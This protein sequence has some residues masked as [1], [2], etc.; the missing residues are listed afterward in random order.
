MLE[1]LNT[2][3]W[4]NVFEGIGVDREEVVDR[5][6]MVWDRPNGD[7]FCA[8]GVFAIK[9]RNYLLVIALYAED[10]C[11]WNSLQVDWFFSTE[12][13][14]NRADALI[15]F[16]PHLTDNQKELLLVPFYLRKH[17]AYLG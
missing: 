7:K 9:N 2:K 17:S 6:S 15:E 5:V 14:Q 3:L 16:L 13:A 10:D 12:Q 8:L 4:K 1:V 11:S